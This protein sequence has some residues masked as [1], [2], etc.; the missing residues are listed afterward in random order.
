MVFIEFFQYHC[1]LPNFKSS[2]AR[3]IEVGVFPVPPMYMLPTQITGIA[4]LYFLLIQ[5]LKKFNNLRNTEIG[6]SK[7]AKNLFNYAL[8]I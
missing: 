7:M 2:F 3:K 6:K 5:Y 8:I 1:F 4:K